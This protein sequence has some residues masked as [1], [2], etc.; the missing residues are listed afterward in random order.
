MLKIQFLNFLLLF[1]EISKLL[2]YGRYFLVIGCN[3]KKECC[4]VK[5]IGL[6][7]GK[8]L[9]ILCHYGYRV[10][11]RLLKCKVVRK[12]KSIQEVRI[13]DFLFIEGISLRWWQGRSRG[14]LDFLINSSYI[15]EKNLPLER[16]QFLI[17]LELVCLRFNAFLNTINF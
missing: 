4:L 10:H 11:C 9:D 2:G 3:L 1:I 8:F 13:G 5:L 17:V 7:M 15:E 16:S 12:E 6:M 14:T